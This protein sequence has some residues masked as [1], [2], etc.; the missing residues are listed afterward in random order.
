MS[1]LD[2]AIID[3]YASIGDSVD[4]IACFKPIR[5]TF[6]KRLPKDIQSLV[7]DGIV[8]RLFQ[9]R[10]AKRLEVKHREN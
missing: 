7:D 1:R 9:L 3:T 4:R 6:L 8:W 5:L 2:Q 10:K